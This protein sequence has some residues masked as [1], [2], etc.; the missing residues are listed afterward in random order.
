MQISGEITEI[1]LIVEYNNVCKH[2]KYAS[3][4]VS[5]FCRCIFFMGKVSLSNTNTVTELYQSRYQYYRASVSGFAQRN[6]FSM[7]GNRSRTLAKPNKKRTTFVVLFLFGGE[8]GIRTL[9]PVTR[10]T[11]L[12][13]EPL[14]HL[15]NSPSAD[16][17]IC[18]H[19]QHNYYITAPLFCQALF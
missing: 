16:S 12:A 8:Q 13:G 2:K 19:K 5:N 6:R 14:H 17:I 1:I 15:G 4:K 9:A 7:R 18:L 11:P 3:P 10:P